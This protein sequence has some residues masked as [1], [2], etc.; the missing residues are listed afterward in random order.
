MA[1]LVAQPITSS[2]EPFTAKHHL[3][4][5]LASLSYANLCFINVWAEIGGHEYD[6]WRKYA[7]SWQKVVAVTLDILI[8]ALA[9]WLVLY[10]AVRS[11]K[12]SWMRT[13]KWVA[14]VGI[15]LPLNVIRTDESFDSLREAYLPDAPVL[16]IAAIVLAAAACLFLIYNWER[17]S[18][19]IATTILIVLAPSMPLAVARATWHTWS[20]PAAGLVSQQP[21]QPALPQPAG[22]SHVIWIIFDEWDH[23]LTFRERPAGLSLPELDRFRSEAFHASRAY[24]PA[25]YTMVSIPSLLTGKTF[26]ASKPQNSD[27]LMLTYD[28]AQPPVGL[29]SQ[30]TIFKEARSRGW[31][32]GIVGWYLPYCRLFPDC[33]AC[34]WFSPMGLFHN[35]EDLERPSSVVRW[36]AQTFQRQ[37]WKVPGFMRA[38]VALMARRQKQRHALAYE[39]VHDAM[40]RTVTDPRL[41]LVYVHMSIPHLPAIY[42]AST[43]TLSSAS[44][45]TYVDNL[46]LVDRTIRD[47]RRK[48]S[49]SGMWDSSTILLTADHPLRV[50]Q[51]QKAGLAAYSWKRTLQQFR[52]F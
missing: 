43:D 33:T 6:F 45:T 34:A 16:Q 21:L 2:G 42:L 28:L 26:I 19:R 40:L 29:T 44:N 38:G 3:K 30:S 25:H 48:L 12:R 49:D 35:L 32:V 11:G 37:V 1:L 51:L 22:A 10:L 47:L 8:V 14:M 4:M 13:V 50:E 5:F 18:T 46:R 52:I 41:N 15:L 7:V 36:M 20:A 23:A 17:L 27:E 24:P 31:N 39:E 9:V